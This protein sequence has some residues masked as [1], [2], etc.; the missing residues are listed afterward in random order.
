MRIGFVLSGV[1]LC[2]TI[3]HDNW[4]TIALALLSAESVEVS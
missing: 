3:G 2:V 4:E 1:V